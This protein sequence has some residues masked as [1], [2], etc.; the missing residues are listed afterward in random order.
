VYRCP[1]TGPLGAALRVNFS[2]NCYLDPMTHPPV[3]PRGVLHSAIINPSQKLSLI[4]EDPKTMRNASFVPEGTAANGNFVVH[5]GRVNVGYCD[6]H[7]ES[8]KDKMVRD[9]QRPK[10]VDRYFDTSKW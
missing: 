4:N 9:I 2:M 10:N 3:A 7:L 1:S 5:N 8:M 6:G